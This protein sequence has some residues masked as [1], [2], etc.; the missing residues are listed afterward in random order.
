MR[1]LCTFPSYSV[2][3]NC[4]RPVFDGTAK[5]CYL[6]GTSMASPH[7]AGVAALIESTGVREARDVQD[8][9]TD[10]ADPIPC[11][12]AA[13]LALYAPF[14]SVKNDAPQQRQGKIKNNG[15]VR[16][17]AGQCRRRRQRAE[18]QAEQLA[19]HPS[20][21]RRHPRRCA[22]CSGMNRKSVIGSA[23]A[24]SLSALS[25]TVR[26]GPPA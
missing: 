7:V 20:A 22:A 1:V 8:I 12:T 19:G 4:T 25:T 26:R 16:T 5:Y 2:G 18:Q 9:V 14:P 21:A 24:Q 11:P 13:Q 23:V 10:T 3:I 15:R 6:Q 17:R